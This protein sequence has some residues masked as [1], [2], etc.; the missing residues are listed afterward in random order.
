MAAEYLLLQLLHFILRVE[1]FR[2]SR[3][4]PYAAALGMANRRKSRKSAG[5][6]IFLHPSHRVLP[7]HHP[8]N[9]E[10]CSTMS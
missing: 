1:R 3:T 6:G 8:C 10:Y 5:A 2:L 4:V 7:R 9:Q